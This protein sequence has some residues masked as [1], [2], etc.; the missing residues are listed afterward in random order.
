VD[1]IPSCSIQ[2]ENIIVPSFP[3]YEPQQDDKGGIQVRRAKSVFS[4]SFF[5]SQVLVCLNVVQISKDFRFTFINWQTSINKC[6]HRLGVGAVELSLSFIVSHSLTFLP[7][8]HLL[9]LNAGIRMRK[10]V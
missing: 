8:Y 3:I 5:F 2:R 10:S 7:L 1:V 9:D 6:E 4:F